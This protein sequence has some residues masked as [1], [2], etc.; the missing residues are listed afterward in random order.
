MWPVLLLLAA[1]LVPTACVLYFMTEAMRNER[2]AVR[3]KLEQVYRGQLIDAR[4]QLD[5]YWRDKLTALTE[6]DPEAGAAQVFASLVT[7]AVCDSALIYDSTGRLSYPAIAPPS[8]VEKEPDTEDWVQAGKLEYDELDAG[9]AATLYGKIAEKAENADV[10]AR[11]LQAQARCLVRAGET[12]AAIEILAAKLA[13]PK[14]RDAADS[15]GRFIVPN[16]QLLA[17]QLMGDSAHPEFSGTLE[18]LVEG[19]KDYRQAAMPSSQRRFLMRELVTL[20]PHPPAFPT[21]AA[22][23]LAADVVETGAPI[24]EASGLQ[25]TPLGSVWQLASPDRTAVGLF[26]QERILADMREL[27]EGQISLADVSAR[28]L[29]PSEVHPREPFLAIPAGEHLPDWQLALYL[30]G[31]DPFDAAADRQVAAYFWTGL[32]VIVIIALL[33]LLVARHLG[34]QM[35]L[36]RL[37]NDFIATVSHELKT[38]L[39]STR[40]LVDT[41]LE[42]N[43]RDQQQV[44]EYLRL[45]AKENE[46]LS[47]LIDN[48]LTFSRMERKKEA[49]E[50]AEV[51]PG[52]IVTSA[53][54]VVASKFEA[55]GF[56]FDVHA[57]P[58]LPTVLADRDALAT[59]LLN[60][61]DNAYKYSGNDRQ[62]AL[63]AYE[64]D[65]QVCFEV[66][67]HGMGMSRRAS[68][69]VFDRFYQA[70]RS[71]SRS[72]GGCGLGLSIVQFIVKAHGG[73]V[74][75]ASEP[76]KGST[77][78]VKLP[79]STGR[80]ADK[81]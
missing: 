18:H 63:R 46:R 48:F 79:A 35:K 76:G 68:R 21:L 54:E 55:A 73:R 9:G 38:P 30:E 75:V 27:I 32:L 71:L 50:F 57:E 16:A 24:P 59:V 51:S 13:E 45:V 10:A 33:A 23:E 53:A 49:F 60:L 25:P 64:V 62:V 1:V 11:A 14:F 29:V 39:S 36:A 20:V 42:G 43:Y 37:K 44:G 72:A 40:V 81:P 65:G 80:H 5:K 28:V 52:D 12:Q 66:E 77:F 74:T 7:T 6:I 67:D 58:I 34:R 69:K 19:L 3:Q 15:L 17:L 31:P 56:R 8:A 47:H 4:G 70:D 61:L 41:L 26:L 2:L 22:E 78:T